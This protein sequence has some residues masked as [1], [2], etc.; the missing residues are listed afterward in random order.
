MADFSIVSRRRFL[1]LALTAGGA[2]GG[3]GAAGLWLLRGQAPPVTGLRCLSAHEYRTL[4]RLVEALFPAGGSFAT[5]G[6]DI[7][8]ARAFDAFLADEPEHNRRDLK[9]ALLWLELGPVLYE[10]RMVTFS[11]IAPA[12]RLAHFDAWA[13]SD[14]DTRRQVTVAFRK[15]L[16]LVFYDQPAVW[17]SIGYDGPVG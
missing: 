3:G 4:A 11:N 15:F 10:R 7:A 16:S 9:R 14:D 1:A 2:L 5:S 6:D 17:S 12:E 8:L 13:E